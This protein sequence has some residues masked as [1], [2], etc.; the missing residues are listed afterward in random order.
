MTWCIMYAQ[1]ILLS[2]S[3]HPLKSYLKRLGK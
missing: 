1:F 3:V 2:V